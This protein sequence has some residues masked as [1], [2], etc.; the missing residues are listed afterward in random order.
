MSVQINIVSKTIYECFFI[1]MLQDTILPKPPRI[2]R[3]FSF[4]QWQKYA[5]D[6][7]VRK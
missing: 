4:F 3:T 7:L 2:L 1:K 5:L 6:S